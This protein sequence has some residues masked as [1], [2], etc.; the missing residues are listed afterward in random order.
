MIHRADAAGA[1]IAAL[2]RGRPGQIYNVVDDE[3]VTQLRFFEWLS[4]ATGRPL[5]PAAAEPEAAFNRAP[6]NKKVSNRK[7]KAE[8]GYRFKF[9]T[10]REG[11]EAE[12]AVTVSMRA[13]MRAER[14]AESEGE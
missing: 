6:T 1:I 12:F 8:L 9:P 14:R 10:F 11:Y 4:R 3:P 5:P 7:L 2:E 13:A